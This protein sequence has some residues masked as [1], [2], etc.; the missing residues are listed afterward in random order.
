MQL[1]E[2]NAGKTGD[3]LLGEWLL[4]LC[5]DDCISLPFIFAH[6]FNFSFLAGTLKNR[7]LMFGI[8]TISPLSRLFQGVWFHYLW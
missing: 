3:P 2:G 6:L 5:V 1:R 4:L 7:T 8:Q